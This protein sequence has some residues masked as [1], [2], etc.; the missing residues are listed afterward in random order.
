[1][2][3]LVE[4]L[5]QFVLKHYEDGGHWVYETHDD[6]DYQAVLDDAG[7]N[8]DDAKLKLQEYWELISEREQEVR[9]EIF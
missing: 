3:N 6:E 2:Q 5:K 4:E 9:A 7:G 1:M 8:I